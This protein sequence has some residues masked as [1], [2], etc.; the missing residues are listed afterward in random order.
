MLSSFASAAVVVQDAAR[1]EADVNAV[2]TNSDEFRY[3][4]KP[5]LKPAKAGLTWADFK[6]YISVRRNGLV[7]FGTASTWFLLDVAYYCNNLYTPEIVKVRRWSQTLG[8][9]VQEVVRTSCGA[10]SWW[11]GL[12]LRLSGLL[13][14]CA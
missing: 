10:S 13:L 4:E 12:L 7:L 8:Y 3:R 5:E 14:I 2:L 6:Q 9:P 1:A 11:A